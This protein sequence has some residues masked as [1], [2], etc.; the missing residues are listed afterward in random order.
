[1]GVALEVQGTKVFKG[2]CR[3]LRVD[4][5]LLRIY[6]QRLSDLD[7]REVWHVQNKPYHSG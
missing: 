6:S 7:V 4:V 5:A 1:M 2:D 3:G